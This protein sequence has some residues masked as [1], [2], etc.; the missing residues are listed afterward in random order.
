MWA[1]TDLNVAGSDLTG[2]S[3]ALQPAIKVQGRIAFSTP[4][5]GRDP[6]V[7]IVLTDVSSFRALA[8]TG[9]MSPNVIESRV[10]NDGTFEIPDVVPGRYELR[11]K[12]DGWIASSAM[13]GAIMLFVF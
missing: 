4:P 7:Q 11:V 12:V 13:L 2:I 3:L 10:K 1:R 9:L 8:M 6:A 5:V